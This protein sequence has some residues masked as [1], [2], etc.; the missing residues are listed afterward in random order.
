MHE[1]SSQGKMTPVFRENNSGWFPFAPTQ[2]LLVKK[3]K[4]TSKVIQ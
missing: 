2:P 4:E 1:V 3:V